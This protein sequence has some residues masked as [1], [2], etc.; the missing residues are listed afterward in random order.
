MDIVIYLY[1]MENM[2]SQGSLVQSK[3]L[4][5]SISVSPVSHCHQICINHSIK[6]VH[7][8]NNVCLGS[9]EILWKE[10]VNCV[11]SLFQLLLNKSFSRLLKRYSNPPWCPSAMIYPVKGLATKERHLRFHKY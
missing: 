7:G 6:L 4:P 1:T 3:T 5:Y 2:K 9:S 10:M 11:I 8:S